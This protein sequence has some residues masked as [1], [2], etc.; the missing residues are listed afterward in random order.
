[1]V[2]DSELFKFKFLSGGALI[3][4]FSKN[5]PSHPLVW[6]LW[7]GSLL[8]PKIEFFLQLLIFE[9]GVFSKLVQSSFFYIKKGSF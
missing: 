2:F 5:H 4:K 8:I 1:M 3:W 9:D 7:Q 6:T